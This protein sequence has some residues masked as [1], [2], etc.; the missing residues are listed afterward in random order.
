MIKP[1]ALALAALLALS[2]CQDSPSAEPAERDPLAFQKV[3]AAESAASDA[4]YA[5]RLDREARAAERSAVE[6]CA[7]LAPHA[8]AP[9]AAEALDALGAYDYA[10]GVWS[11]A[12]GDP[13]GYSTAE[14]STVWNTQ[15]CAEAAPMY[16]ADAYPEEVETATA[17][18]E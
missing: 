11:N 4:A 18:S 2:A 7:I 6:P 13:I 16:P 14:D 9:D 12:Y 15:A 3:D 1:A 5:E 8:D 17:A 10:G